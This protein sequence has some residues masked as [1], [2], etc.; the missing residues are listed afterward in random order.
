LTPH[1]QH[2]RDAL[3]RQERSDTN[4]T[5]EETQSG[6]R[7]KG[8]DA[9]L[10]HVDQ[11]RPFRVS[12]CRAPLW[13]RNVSAGAH[14]GNS[15]LHT[16]SVLCGTCPACHQSRREASEHVVRVTPH[17]AV[18]VW[19]CKEALYLKKRLDYMLVYITATCPDGPRSVNCS[20]LEAQVLVWN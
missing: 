9:M 3:D 16:R 5:A 13:R 8:T 18:R 19:E 6:G 7:L 4:G 14:I 2:Q 12:P 10:G 20:Q 17:L 15:L 1:S 11:H